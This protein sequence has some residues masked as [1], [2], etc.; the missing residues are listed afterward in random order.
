M[1]EK[2]IL[3]IFYIFKY[4]FIFYIF[5]I[6]YIFNVKSCLR[7]QRSCKFITVSGLTA[8]ETWMLS[9]LLFVFGALV[10]ELRQILVLSNHHCRQS[11]IC[12]SRVSKAISWWI[13]YGNLSLG[14]VTN[15]WKNPDHHEIKQQQKLFLFA[16]YAVILFNKQ[17]VVKQGVPHRRH[18]Q[19]HANNVKVEHTKTYSCRYI[20]SRLINHDSCSC[21]LCSLYF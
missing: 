13:F 14:L 3:I 5:Y 21:R 9:C 10:G 19:S 11:A 7:S 4:F 6:F 12:R 1:P 18:Q 16:E 2:H 17:K 8:I 20:R 15:S